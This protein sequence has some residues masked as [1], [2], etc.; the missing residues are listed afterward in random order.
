MPQDNI[1]IRNATTE[2][3][4]RLLAIYTPYVE[5]TAITYDI[6]GPSLEEFR[7]K[8]TDV[9]RE[10]PFLVAEVNG[11]ITGYCYAH[12]FI[13][14]EASSHCAEMSIY[15]EQD[16]RKTGVGRRLYAEMEDRLRK[17]GIHNLYAQVTWTDEE[18]EYLTNAST[19]FHERMGYVK[20]GHYHECGRKFNRTFDTI[21]LEKII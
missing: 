10:Y 15:V 8:I 19:A 1:T 12:R 17:Q 14:R 6:R 20:A 16:N 3:A 13:Q 2:D 18:N 7:R 21:V 9:S 11:R 4:A 5:H